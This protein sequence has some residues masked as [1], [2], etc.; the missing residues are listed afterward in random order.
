MDQET[1]MNDRH[2]G[3]WKIA[4]GEGCLDV[5]PEGATV[6]IREI[7]GGYCRISWDGQDKAHYV[8]TSFEPL[9]P[10]HGMSWLT[11]TQG[12]DT[13]DRW[14][15]TFARNC[16]RIRVAVARKSGIGGTDLTGTWGAEASGPPDEDEAGKG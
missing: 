4:P 16:N 7:D 3:L 6:Y 5:Y 8:L 9:A 14:N 2:F 10:G 13:G 1:Q 11:W 15:L 12:D